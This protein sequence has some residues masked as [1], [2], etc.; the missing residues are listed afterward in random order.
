MLVIGL[1]K[2]FSVINCIMESR[3]PMSCIIR[4]SLV[5]PCLLLFPFKPRVP[6]FYISYTSF[7][8]IL[9][10]DAQNVREINIVFHSQSRERL[11]TIFG[12]T[13]SK[14][15]HAWSDT[16]KSTMPRKC[17]VSSSCCLQTSFLGSL[18][19]VVHSNWSLV[20]QS[21]GTTSHCLK[22]TLSLLSL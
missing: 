17:C 18:F 5:G 13:F 1:D 11:N 2:Y 16:Y 20:C 4:F 19:P 10:P 3:P 15:S 14:P 6:F 8:I 12:K 9:G 22:T 21:F 7:A